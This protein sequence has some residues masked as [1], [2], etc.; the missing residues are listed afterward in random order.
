M[1]DNSQNRPAPDRPDP[2]AARQCEI[3]ESARARSGMTAY[4]YADQFV[5]FTGLAATPHEWARAALDE[6][7]GAKGQFVWRV[8]LGL[9]LTRRSG[10]EQVAGWRI[11]DRGDSWITLE[12]RSWLFVGRLVVEV[13]DGS[14]SL[15]CFLR[16]ERPLG[17]RVWGAVS[18]AH[19]RV[20]PLL[21]TD[22][23]RLLPE[24]S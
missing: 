17:A 20:A 11:A 15:A 5:L 7:A 13:L 16:Y 1:T 3:T 22:A 24:R 21:L 14:V 4:D 6:A 10:I 18:P 2:V 9:R 23:R 19:R 8:V 12:A